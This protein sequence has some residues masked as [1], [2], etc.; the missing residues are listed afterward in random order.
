M[1]NAPLMAQ[2]IASRDDGA[3]IR[4]GWSDELDGLVV[5]LPEAQY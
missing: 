3:V 4:E 5:R 1:N 2:Q